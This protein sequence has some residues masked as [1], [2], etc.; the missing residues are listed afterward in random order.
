MAFSSSSQPTVRASTSMKT[1]TRWPEV[2]RCPHF[3][4]RNASKIE[5]R[6]HRS[7]RDERSPKG[8]SA[9]NQAAAETDGPATIPGASGQRSS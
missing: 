7:A 8:A 5:S 6:L 4:G 1:A 3:S 2:W 9:W